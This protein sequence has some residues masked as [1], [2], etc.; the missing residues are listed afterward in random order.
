MAV[1]VPVEEVAGALLGPIVNGQLVVDP[2]LGSSRDRQPQ[3]ERS[4]RLYGQET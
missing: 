4:I 2:Q 1:D 3:L